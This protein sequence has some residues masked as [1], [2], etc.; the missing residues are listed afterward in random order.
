[1]A[2]SPHAGDAIG[3]AFR[4]FLIHRRQAQFFIHASGLL[5]AIDYLDHQ[6]DGALPVRKREPDLRA[7]HTSP[8][9]GGDGGQGRE[10]RDLTGGGLAVPPGA[11]PASGVFEPQIIASE[12]A[13]EQG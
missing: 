13:E 11:K 9:G 4:P 7:G 1:M 12:A 3:P 8:F 6:N 2:T 10:G 5:G